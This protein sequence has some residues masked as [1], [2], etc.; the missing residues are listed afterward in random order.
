VIQDEHA[1]LPDAINPYLHAKSLLLMAGVPSQE[2]RV[3]TLRQPAGSLAYTLQN[4]S[5][6][7]Y[8]KLNGVPWTVDH[9]LPIADEIV[10]GLGIAELATS[11]YHDRRATWA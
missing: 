10:V 7:L 8:A 1:D 3:S 11:R 6:A 2:M 4:A 9:H 5:V